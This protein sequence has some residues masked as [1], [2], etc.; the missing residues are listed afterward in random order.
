M[1]EFTIHLDDPK[2]TLCVLG[3]ASIEFANENAPLSM[4]QIDSLRNQIREQLPKAPVEEPTGDVVVA[5]G[6]WFFKPGGDLGWVRD[7]LKPF[8]WAGV[9]GHTGDAAVYRREPAPSPAEAVEADKAR[10]IGFA[11]ASPHPPHRWFDGADVDLVVPA[12]YD[13]P[14]KPAPAP[15]PA[16]VEADKATL[17]ALRR[18]LTNAEEDAAPEPSPVQVEAGVSRNLAD[19][20]TPAEQAEWEAE[21]APGSPQPVQVEAEPVCTCCRINPQAALSEEPTS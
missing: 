6:G 18:R 12:W 13:C 11:D 1:P 19:Y 8:D 21:Q 3:E 10:C 16:A 5:R 15:S 20:R 2:A 14:G 4:S 7:D 17:D 9:Q